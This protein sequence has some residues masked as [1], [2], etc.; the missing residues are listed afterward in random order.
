MND[1]SL[2]SVEVR[3]PWRHSLRTRLMLWFGALVG[4]LLVLGF[5][6]AYFAAQRSLVAEAESRTRFEARQA[7]DRL[8]ATMNSVRI[9]AEGVA[10]LRQRLE[11]DRGQWIQAMEA[12]VQADGTAVG[13][14]LALEPGVLPDGAPMGYYVGNERLG[15]ADRDL[16]GDGYDVR[17][18]GWYQA[19]LAAQGPWW[20]D[21][22]FN[23]TA[24]GTWM[25]TINLPLRDEGGRALGMVSL[26]VP[27]RRLNEL[28][29]PLRAVP[30]QRPTL[31]SPGGSIA[32][33]PD[34]GIALTIDL[35]GYMR[36]YGR[37]DLAPV[38]QAHALRQPLELEHTLAG[39]GERRYSVLTPIGSTG[40][41]LQLAL[42]HDA[43]LADLRRQGLW[44]ALGAALATLVVAVL[45]R[46]LAKRITVPLSE[47]TGSAGHFAVG[48]F[49]WPV[50]H[51][52]RGDEVG[53][54]A[55]A[56]ER[57]RDSIRF[58]LDEIADMASER[59]KLESELDI[60]RDIQLA[61][62]PAP[63]AVRHGGGEAV[64]GALLKPAKAVGGDF[65][66]FFD[67]LDGQ[68]WFV[69]GDVSD[70]GV[71]AALFMARTVTVLEVAARLG[72]SPARAL[73]ES[74]R[75]LVEGNDTCMFATVA[76]GKLDLATGALEM[77]SAGHEPPVML[78]RGAAPAWLPLPGGPPLGFE[79]EAVFETWT[80]RLEP[81]DG[82]VLYTDGVTEAF[83]LANVPFGEQ[84]L[85]GV[86]GEARGAA[87][88]CEALLAAVQAHAGE[89]PQS[90]DIT[91]L[92]ICY[93]RHGLE[94][95]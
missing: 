78:R 71:P 40:W 43:I 18:Q 46:R 90:D 1:L 66:T 50:P 61:M 59:Q 7:S 25:T 77:A 64:L 14:L 47:L 10:A 69:I 48:E 30:G 5:G 49:D 27:V 65:Y 67:T 6:V 83:D 95:G 44:L 9:S 34:A 39:T 51:D 82:L 4:S 52:T 32:V 3:V 93:Q 87:A 55:R 54:M 92:A 75:H 45:V 63:R 21:P 29:D 35:P 17:A 68:L 31:L 72:G 42:S 58:Q 38:Q 24:G 81:G 79:A 16:L 56:L 62:L 70:K 86:L 33:H 2:Q 60:A 15:V 41:S 8:L 88:T 84:R 74:A 23:E 20:S 26:D 13:G 19:T 28:L 53:V 94:E 12:L 89:A 73:A 11:L 22:Y 37:E 36:E 57:A 76:C 80:G 91:L 85:L